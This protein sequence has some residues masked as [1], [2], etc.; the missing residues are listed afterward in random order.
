V[1]SVECSALS[2]ESKQQVW[3]TREIVMDV[4]DV[5]KYPTFLHLTVSC[6]IAD[7]KDDVLT[8]L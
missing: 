4:H 6:Q 2:M 5:I 1:T 7:R 3:Q 8:I